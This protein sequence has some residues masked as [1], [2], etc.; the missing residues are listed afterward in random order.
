MSCCR[1]D[2]QRSS[3]N[4][5]TGSSSR[6]SSCWGGGGGSDQW[7]LGKPGGGAVCSIQTGAAGGPHLAVHLHQELVQHL[8]PVLLLPAHLRH[9]LLHH[10]VQLLRGGIKLDTAHFGRQGA[11]IG[12]L[13]RKRGGVPPRWESAM[14]GPHCP[15]AS[16]L[17]TELAPGLSSTPG[18][19]QNDQ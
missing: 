2:F 9:Q 1:K 16:S 18:L 4:C 6:R 10:V 11:L 13:P 17:D 19:S 7:V 3:S 12:F 5:F 8:L 14:E 15:E